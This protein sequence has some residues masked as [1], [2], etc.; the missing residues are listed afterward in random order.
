MKT[1]IKKEYKEK[2]INAKSGRQFMFY[3]LQ[4]LGFA[5][6]D[7]KSLLKYD[8]EGVCEVILKDFHKEL[9]DRTTHLPVNKCE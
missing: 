9:L 2:A 7:I 5:E 3:T 8:Y 6:G 4:M 1:E